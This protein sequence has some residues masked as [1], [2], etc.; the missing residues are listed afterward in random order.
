MC[1]IYLPAVVHEARFEPLLD[2]NVYWFG[3]THRSVLINIFSMGHSFLMKISCLY[4]PPFWYYFSFFVRLLLLAM[5]FEMHAKMYDQ[6]YYICW[7]YGTPFLSIHISCVGRHVLQSSSTQMKPQ[8][9]SNHEG[10]GSCPYSSIFQEIILS[11]KC[12]SHCLCLH[13]FRNSEHVKIQLI[14][15]WCAQDFGCKK[16]IKFDNPDVF[17]HKVEEIPYGIQSTLV[18][19]FFI[20]C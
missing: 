17:I 9:S 18:S 6:I 11:H 2:L 16:G 20:Q 7:H 5:I 8:S 10:T 1:F 14:C 19:V 4:F 12:H 15:H 13:G 3:F